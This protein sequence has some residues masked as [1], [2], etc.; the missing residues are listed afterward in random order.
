MRYSPS[1]VEQ[2][3]VDASHKKRLL[4][5]L[6]FGLVLALLFLPDI[7]SLWLDPSYDSWAD[8]LA[9]PLIGL[10]SLLAVFGRKLWLLLLLL[11]PFVVLA[12]VETAYIATYAKPSNSSIIATIA[13]SNLREAREYLGS[14]LFPLIFCVTVATLLAVFSVISARTAALRIPSMARIA[15]LAATMAAVIR[16]YSLLHQQVSVAIEAGYPF[17]FPLRVAEYVA[18]SRE[19]R[20]GAERLARFRFGAHM[21]SGAGRRI[22]VLVI[23]ES[24]RRDRWQMFGYARATNPEL[25]LVRNLVKFDD[26]LT[27]RPISIDAIPHLLTRKPIEKKVPLWREP[28]ILRLM[29]EAGYET[30]W[31]SN[32]LKISEIDS[33]I[34][35][36]AAQAQHQK[37]VNYSSWASPGGYDESLLKPLQDILDD[38]SPTNLFVVL[39]T[40]GSHGIYD[41]RYPAPFRRFR[42]V[43]SDPANE[44]SRVERESNSYDNTILY[45]DHLL[46]QVIGMLE[47]GGGDSM[48]FFVSDHGETLPTA[49][50]MLQGHG[51]ATRYE[52]EIPAFLWYSDRFATEY[53]DKIAA[54]RANAK[55]K[56]LSADLFESLADAADVQYPGQQTSRSLFSPDWKFRTRMVNYVTD[57]DHATFDARCGVVRPGE[58]TQ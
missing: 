29:T 49:S 31:L 9:L 6:T 45:T 25:A 56:T 27:V 19:I 42:P 30:Y 32:Q 18:D 8:A 26:M 43:T 13:A 1:A 10:A 57:F 15:V 14:A 58:L 39:H 35:I 17:G 34:S 24:S 5:W 41:F 20:A 40:M 53:P 44:G 47:A 38:A 37:F 11:S 7:V 12:P 52:F 51:R 4:A 48:L 2:A 28:S 33:P 46:A 22:I 50:C 55:Q 21:K 36:Y 3:T 16:G 23:G 54:A